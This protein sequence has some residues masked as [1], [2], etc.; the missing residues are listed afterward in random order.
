[1]AGTV[2]L[3]QGSGALE[4]DPAVLERDEEEA[5]PGGTE[6]VEAREVALQGDV[7]IGVVRAERERA[8]PWHEPV[9]DGAQPGSVARGAP[10]VRRPHRR[11]RPEDDE[12][13]RAV[14]ERVREVDERVLRADEVAEA[15]EG[16]GRLPGGEDGHQMRPPARVTRD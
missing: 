16:R 8:A 2:E 3:R 10:L 13:E 9:E 1:A 4:D 6:R 7:E 5:E 14:D 12:R 11:P 15:G